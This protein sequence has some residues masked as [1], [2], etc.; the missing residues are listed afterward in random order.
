MT[1]FSKSF[2]RSRS[3]ALSLFR[4][5]S[6]S[7]FV[8]SQPKCNRVKHP[9]IYFNDD[10]V[11][12]DNTK[13]G[14]DGCRSL[15]LARSLSLPL[16]RSLFLAPSLSLTLS[17]CLIAISR[18]AQVDCQK[19]CRVD[20]RPTMDSLSLS[21]TLSH[22]RTRALSRILTVP[23]SRSLALFT[24][25]TAEVEA[26]DSCCASERTGNGGYKSPYARNMQTHTR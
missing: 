8:S 1:G 17:R 10:D 6:I 4:S 15:A 18:D 2:C 16:L 23:L 12:D 3:L 14:M 21:L 13:D 20:K 5:L 22:S 25:K 24:T 7:L 19:S 9:V 26:V 11:D